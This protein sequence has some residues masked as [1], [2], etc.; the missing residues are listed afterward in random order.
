MSLHDGL[1]HIFCIVLNAAA[2]KFLNLELKKNVY[3][4]LFYSLLRKDAPS[5]GGKTD[6]TCFSSRASKLMDG[7]QTG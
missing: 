3:S 1:L 7:G 6:E 2:V 4:I 5:P